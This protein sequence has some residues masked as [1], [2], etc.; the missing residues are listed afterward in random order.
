MPK[1]P[2]RDAIGL[3]LTTC[4]EVNPADA[5]VVRIKNTLNL[6]QIW[7]SEPVLRDPANQAKLEPL[8]PV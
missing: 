6:S 5:K 8:T 1:V 2:N 3:G 7:V 4:N